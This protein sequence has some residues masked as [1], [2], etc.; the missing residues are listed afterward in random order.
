MGFHSVTK[1]SG[2]ASG[3]TKGPFRLSRVGS[4]PFSSGHG[5]LSGGGCLPGGPLSEE[6]E[7]QNLP[8][9]SKGKPNY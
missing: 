4:A 1:G 7:A 6:R 3:P 8:R 9:D 5:A 2:K